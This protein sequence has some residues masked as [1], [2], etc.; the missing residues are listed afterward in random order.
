MTATNSSGELHPS[1]G[2]VQF[3]KVVVVLLLDGDPAD[4]PDSSWIS[5]P[6]KQHSIPANSGPLSCRLG[7]S[8]VRVLNSN[9]RGKRFLAAAI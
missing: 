9:L 5:L 2:C 1:S 8:T 6:A 7:G 3:R 4:Q